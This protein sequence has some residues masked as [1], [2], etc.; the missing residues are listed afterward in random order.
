MYYLSKSFVEVE[1]ATGCYQFGYVK[2]EGQLVGQLNNDGSKLFMHD[3]LEGSVGVV[4]NSSGSIIENTTY[5]PFGEIL[6]GGSVSRFDSEGKEFDSIVGDTDFNFRKM[7]PSWGLF[8]QPDTLIQNVYDPQS[9][10]RYMFER[11]NPYGRT[12]PS[13]HDTPSASELTIP[14]ISAVPPI[15]ELLAY[16]REYKK[17]ATIAVVNQDFALANSLNANREAYEAVYFKK[18]IRE[19]FAGIPLGGDDQPPAPYPGYEGGSLNKHLCKSGSACLIEIDE[20]AG[21]SAQLQKDQNLVYSKYGSKLSSVS[22]IA[23]LMKK[24]GS[25]GSGGDWKPG[26]PFIKVDKNDKRNALQRFW[27][28]VKTVVTPKKTSASKQKTKTK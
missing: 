26:D 25:P 16:Q 12:D 19:F 3:D 28:R 14:V 9:L 24:E 18:I 2:H 1:N 5:S 13:G 10:N 22:E 15:I 17:L 27:D 7:N 11:G 21:A 6:S 20:T 23:N 8:L 4:T